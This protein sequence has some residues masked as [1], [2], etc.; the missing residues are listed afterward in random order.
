MWKVQ[1]LIEMLV[2]ILFYAFIFIVWCRGCNFNFVFHL[3]ASFIL[4]IY[5][6]SL[7]SSAKKNKKNKKKIKSNHFYHYCTYLGRVVSCR[8]LLLNL[9]VR[10]AEFFFILYSFNVFVEFDVLGWL[11]VGVGVVVVAVVVAVAVAVVVVV[12]R[13]VGCTVAWSP[14]LVCWLAFEL[15]LNSFESNV[16]LILLRKLLSLYTEWCRLKEALKYRFLLRY[17]WGQSK[18]VRNGHL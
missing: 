10:Y 15:L 7:F 17:L 1:F 12:A 3:F 18:N 6:A 5:C 14:M 8:C 13:V 9:L 11:V 4:F 16:R 2:F